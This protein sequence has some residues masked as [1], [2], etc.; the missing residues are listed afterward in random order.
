MSVRRE[1]RGERRKGDGERW[2][3]ETEKEAK[4]IKRYNYGSEFYTL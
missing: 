2:R 1:G 4:G 3:E